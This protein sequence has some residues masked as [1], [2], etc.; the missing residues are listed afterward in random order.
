MTPSWLDRVTL[1][2]SPRWALRRIR[3]RVAANMLLRHYEGASVGRRTQGWRR[4]S[5]DANAAMTGGLSRLRDH[6]RDLVRNNPHGE[7]AVSTIADHTVGWGIVAQPR[8]PNPAAAALWDAWANTT[9][10]DADGRLDFSGIQKLVMR[11]VVES[12]EALVRLRIRRVE[13][14]LPIPLQI[15]VLEPDYIDTAQADVRLPNGGRIIHGVEFDAIGRR[16]AYWMHSEHPG[17]QAITSSSS[18]RV[19][20]SGVLHIYR[21]QRPGQVRGASWFAPV[22]LTMK[23]FDEYADAQLVKQK[24][25][26]CLAVITTDPDGSHTPLGIGTDGEGKATKPQWDE[27]GPGAIIHAPPGRDVTVVDPP[28]VGDYGAYSEITLRAIATGLGVS[29]EDL[30]GDYTDLPFSAARMS[31]LR[32]WGRV[33]DWRWQMLI[34]QLCDPVWKWAMELSMLMG[35]VREVPRVDWTAPP[36]PMIEPDKEGLA[37]QRN[38]RTG[39]ISLSEALRERGYDPKRVLEELSDDFKKLDEL[40]LILDSDPRNTTQ[41]G[42]FQAVKNTGN[43]KGNGSGNGKAA[44][45]S[46]DAD[47]DE[48]VTEVGLMAQKLYLPVNSPKPLISVKEARTLM[49]RLGAGL[50]G[51]P[52]EELPDEPAEVDEETDRALRRFTKKQ[53]VQ[54]LKIITKRAN[55]D[56]TH[57]R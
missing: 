9:A 53:L 41:G 20:A 26:A 12:G 23:E 46:G 1:Q 4:T 22:I 37:Y 39:I 16:V 50:E 52:D 33:E 43:G 30:T 11:T 15:Q 49:N 51:E 48:D 28:R 3:A 6:A 10:C 27:L 54:L 55:G 47:T 21:Q 18:S 40:G 36:L 31:R 8:K 2:F 44:A 38:I 35:S 45:S 29:Y 25:A 17:S 7:S 5:T 57:V 24:V 19:P 14:E 42:Q 13:D 32:H 56:A 34:P